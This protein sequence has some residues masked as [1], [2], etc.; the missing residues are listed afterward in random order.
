MVYISQGC[1][2]GVKIL[3]SF[4][5]GHIMI[6]TLDYYNTGAVICMLI[7]SLLLCAIRFLPKRDFHALTVIYQH[8]IK[9]PFKNTKGSIFMN[10]DQVRHQ[11]GIL[12]SL[13]ALQKCKSAT[14]I[15]LGCVLITYISTI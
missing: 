2:N 13:K 6:D 12:M 1:N 11:R 15:M 5:K 4:K 3:L 9:Y 8:A 14:G 7:C 10:H